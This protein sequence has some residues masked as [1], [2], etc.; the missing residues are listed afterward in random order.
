[1]VA[2]FNETDQSWY[3]GKVELLDQGPDMKQVKVRS[4]DFGWILLF[5]PEALRQ[6]PAAL[7]GQPVRCEKYKM[8]DIR[9]R[10]RFHG[11]SAADR[12]AGAEWLR[13]I[14]NNQVVVAICFKQVRYDGGILADC[15]VA[16]KNLNRAALQRGHAYSTVGMAR[17][18]FRPQPGVRPPAPRQMPVNASVNGAD[19]DYIEYNG[20]GLARP[21]RGGRSA[22]FGMN[23]AG[24]GSGDMKRMDR[25]INEEKRTVSQL[26]NPNLDGTI[27]AATSCSKSTRFGYGRIRTFLRCRILP[28]FKKSKPCR[29]LLCFLFYISLFS[30]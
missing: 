12:Q 4:L 18:P 15:M 19:R 11:Y 3:R 8:M 5:K 13:G 27:K 9:P 29:K 16:D 6:L 7:A 22:N 1:M 21:G 2:V 23:S 30:L 28:N 25:N 26:K 24:R 20:K 10:G 17:P 14:I